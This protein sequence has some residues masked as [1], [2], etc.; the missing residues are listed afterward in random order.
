MIDPGN[1]LPLSGFVAILADVGGLG[2]STGFARRRAAI[3]TA[4]AVTG[5]R[6]VIEVRM[7]PAIG[8]MAIV[9]AVAA[10][11]MIGILAGGR[12]TIVTTDAG[13]D[14]RIVVNPG[15][16]LPLGRFMTGLANVGR[17]DM[18]AGFAGCLRTI[19]TA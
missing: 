9:A 11:N 14:R 13:P 3:M 7:R 10:L 12:L 6:G 19:V 2:V 4:D 16:R 15:D 17:L 5:D 1:R 8:G 18:F